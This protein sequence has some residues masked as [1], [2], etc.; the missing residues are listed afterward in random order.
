MSVATATVRAVGPL[1]VTVAGLDF[2]NPVLLAAGT[3]GFAQELD[4]VMALDALG[5]IVTKAVSLLPRTGNRRSEERRVGKE[6][7]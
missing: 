4:E 3:A 2:Q 5:G 1:A 6:C 7:A